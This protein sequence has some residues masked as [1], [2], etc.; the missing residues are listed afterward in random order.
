MGKKQINFYLVLN[1]PPTAGVKEIK[2]AW[3]KQASL[4]HPDKNRGNPLAEKKF[5]QINTAWQTL[6]DPEKRRQ[7][8]LQLRESSAHARRP[9]VSPLASVAANPA[10]PHLKE[11]SLRGTQPLDVKQTLKV[12]L[13][14]LCC[15][16]QK[17]I[18]YT[19]LAD[20]G[21]AKSSFRFKIPKGARPGTQLKFKGRGGGGGKSFGDL[22]VKIQLKPHI[23]FKIMED[24]GDLLLERPVSFVS[25]LR[26]NRLEIPTPY[27]FLTIDV[28]PP[29]QD[30]QLFKIKGYGLPLNP[31]GKKGHLYVKILVDWPL[32]NRLKIQEE[33][34]RLSIARQKIYVEKFKAQSLVYPQV[35]KFQKK[36]QELKSIWRDLGPACANYTHRV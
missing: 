1:I 16:A 35:A 34:N 24:Y 6:K 33:M 23:I 30:K 17:T 36:I 27:G 14:D 21:S 32:K 25:A 13:E 8:D 10:A 7:F 18:D 20:G 5:Q 19:R 12:S 3:I 29:L 11:N 31:A 22:Y 2:Q 4:Y 26:D 28:Q 15:L 9:L